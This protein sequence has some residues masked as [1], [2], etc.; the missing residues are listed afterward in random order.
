[1]FRGESELPEDVRT[2]LR[3]RVETLEQLE[4]LRL[5]HSEPNMNWSLAEL[6]ERLRIAAP[7][8]AGAV[9][10][11]QSGGLIACPTAGAGS[12]YSPADPAIKAAAERL[13]QEYRERPM[14][15][16]QLISTYAIERVRTAALRAFADAFVIRKDADGG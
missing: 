14:R 13:L 6:G 4:I 15:I 7:L 10:A 16:M 1:M 3:T 2:L 12:V 8:V 9:K 11:L 5:V